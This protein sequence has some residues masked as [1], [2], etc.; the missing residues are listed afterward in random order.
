MDHEMNFQSEGSAQAGIIS[1]FFSL[2][3]YSGNW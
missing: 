2:V 1:K 3:S